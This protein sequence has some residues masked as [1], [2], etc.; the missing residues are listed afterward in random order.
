VQLE[1]Q[2]ALM[3]YVTVILMTLVEWPSNRSRIVCCNHR[4]TVHGQL[5]YISLVYIQ[6]NVIC[7]II[8][9]C[10]YCLKQHSARHHC[11]ESLSPLKLCGSAVVRL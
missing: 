7:K 1:F 3:C 4:I 11:T 2:R 5:L 6:N 8:V 10:F 9:N